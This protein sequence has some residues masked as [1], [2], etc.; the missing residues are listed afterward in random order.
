[1][2][3]GPTR[4]NRDRI[5]RFFSSFFFFFFLPKVEEA[6]ATEASEAKGGHNHNPRIRGHKFAPSVN[7]NKKNHHKL[8]S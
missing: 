6:N 3:F 5:E 7:V 8:I 2:T 4:I 1:M